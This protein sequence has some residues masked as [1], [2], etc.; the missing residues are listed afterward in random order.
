[1]F[2]NAKSVFQQ[3]LKDT[4]KTDSSKEV[5]EDLIRLHLFKGAEKNEQLLSLVEVY[6]LLGL[7]KFMD[8]MNLLD[9]RTITFSKERGFK[10]HCPISDLLL[11]SKYRG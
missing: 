1:M 11:L 6:D 10:R 5:I 7:E 9:G 4:L 2:T 3:K 8:L